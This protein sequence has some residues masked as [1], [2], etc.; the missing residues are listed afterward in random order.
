MRF[1]AVALLAALTAVPVTLVLAQR[2]PS[3]PLSD[4]DVAMIARLVGL[5][6]RREAAD[7]ALGA[8]LRSTHPEV[9][10]RAAMAIGRI[11]KPQAAALLTAARADAEPAVVAAVAFATGQLKDPAT[12]GWLGEVVMAPKTPPEVAREAARS[13]GKF[14]TPDAR[15][16]LARYLST[17]PDTQ[18]A[19]PPVK[20]ALLSIGRYNV[21][22]DLA[23]IVKW[24]RSSDADVRWRATWALFRPRDPAA[25]P[26]LL[27]LSA[28]ASA[29]VRF[30]AMRG[31]GPIP[32]GRGRDGAPPAVD[33]GPIAPA[34]LAARLRDGV[35][36][37]DRRVRTEAL[38]ALT[39]YDDDE[40]FKVVLEALD[41]ADSW[42]SVSA[43]EQMARFQSRASM[44]V[45][46][47][48][49]ASGPGK[50]LARRITALAP[51][52]TLAPEAAVELA[53]ALARES[54][55][56]ARAAARQALGR[57]GDA[58]RARLDL[59]T[60]ENPELAAPAQNPNPVPS[61][62]ARTD[63]D[64]RQIVDR[65]IVPHY[66][67]AARP[68]A[69]LETPR[70]QI[71]VELNPGDAPLGVEY[72]VGVVT[73]GAIVGTEFG[74][75][76]PNFVAQQRAIRPGVRLRDEVSLLGLLRGT[77]SWASAGLDTG[78][79]GYTFGSTPQPHNEGNFTAL[80]RIVAGMD[81][82]DRLELGDRIT[83]ARMK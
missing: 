43:A 5:E 68:R 47:L 53:T 26:E 8:A 55:A 59:L 65:W 38:R 72:F 1:P 19:M 20:E 30:W 78:N 15:A 34:R 75:V 28:D 22:E 21:R 3:P 83:G 80:G 73:T 41:S 7:A 9:R 39:L 81:V 69:V 35:R 42:L 62:P 58:G 66:K 67:G 46:R 48:T 10:R 70:G 44:V 31:L 76:V 52:T 45:P 32:A 57:L 29:E 56:T 82:V 24:A 40:S 60:K 71:E 51:L 54:N 13:L 49:A 18:A 79:P 63:A 50:P 61:A 2:Q 37:P 23:P 6:D 12:I 77:L 25:V 33:A 11:A 14:A 64:Y 4:A 27:R 17:A 36:D 74:R 16:V